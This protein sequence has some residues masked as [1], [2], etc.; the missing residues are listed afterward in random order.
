M[1]PLLL[2]LPLCWAVEVKRP[3]GV[4]LT[5][6]SAAGGGSRVREGPTRLLGYTLWSLLPQFP[7][8]WV[9]KVA[10]LGGRVWGRGA[11]RL[12]GL[13]ALG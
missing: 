12:R 3:R 8:L 1:L 6:E 4:S 11:I 5:S 9:G 10:M 2:L 7:G 13:L